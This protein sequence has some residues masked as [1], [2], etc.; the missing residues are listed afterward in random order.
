M[1]NETGP[2]A[3]AQAARDLADRLLDRLRRQPDKPISLTPA[4]AHLVVAALHA[5]HRE[6][7]AFWQISDRFNFFVS[8]GRGYQ[9]ATA[10][11]L[12]SAKAANAA[13]DAICAELPDHDV[14]LRHHSRI[15]AERRP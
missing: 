9:A 1:R 8:T 3:H 2:F 13:Y 7:V 4:T 14:W 5:M 11:A 12:E 6:E 15:I 10:A